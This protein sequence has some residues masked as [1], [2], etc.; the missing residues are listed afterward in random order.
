[1]VM[2]D[3]LNRHMLP[4]YG[5]DW[6][7]APNFARLARESTW[8]RNATTVNDS[9]AAAVPA[10]LTGEQ[11]RAGT[12]PTAHDHPRS[13]FTLFERSHEQTVIE[14]ITAVCPARLCDDAR[15]GTMDRLQSLGSDIEVVVQP[16]T[17]AH[18]VVA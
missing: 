11:P 7:H 14:P 4:P 17:A 6:V 12:P 16:V 15:P 8:Y 2:F 9:T 13:L 5:A 1:M 3:S 18:P 10:Q